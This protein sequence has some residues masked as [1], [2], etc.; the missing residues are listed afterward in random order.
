MVISGSQRV[1][2]TFCAAVVPTGQALGWASGMG[3]AF[4]KTL[5]I[6]GTCTKY[7]FCGVTFVLNANSTHPEC[8]GGIVA[9]ACAM[10]SVDR[11]SQTHVAARRPIV[12]SCA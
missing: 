10:S 8:P 6:A 1:S 7:S 12:I 3:T 11:K 4:Q 9:L 5:F 2:P